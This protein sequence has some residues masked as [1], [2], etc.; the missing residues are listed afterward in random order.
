MEL[1]QRRSLVSGREIAVAL[2]LERRAVR[3]NID[4]LAALDLGVE[5]RRELGRRGGYGLGRGTRLPPIAMSNEEA[6][7]IVVALRWLRRETDP[8]RVRDAGRPP[9]LEP[10]AQLH[11]VADLALSRIQRLLPAATLIRRGT[12]ERS[13]R[14]AADALVAQR[15]ADEA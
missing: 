6:L 15:A 14:V 3:K 11:L 5:I 8:R 12:V 9:S 10:A 4:A 2:G 1:L 7:A 13:L